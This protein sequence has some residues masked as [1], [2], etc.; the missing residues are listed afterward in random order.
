M[1]KN[2]IISA[3]YGIFFIVRIITFIEPLVLQVCPFFNDLKA[4]A[5]GDEGGEGTMGHLQHP[6]TDD[7]INKGKLSLF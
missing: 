3:P 5:L 7:Q 1:K 2:C 4:W 6:L